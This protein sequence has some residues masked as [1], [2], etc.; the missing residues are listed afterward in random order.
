MRAWLIVQEKFNNFDY[1]IFWSPSCYEA[2][3]DWTK[4][5]DRAIHFADEASAIRVIRN[6]TLVHAIPVEVTFDE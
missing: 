5:S 2:M 1:P 3:P 4:S 6:L